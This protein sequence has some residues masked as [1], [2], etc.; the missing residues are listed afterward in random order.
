M[1]AKAKCEGKNARCTVLLKH[2]PKFFDT[3]PMAGWGWSTHHPLNLGRLVSLVAVTLCE[4]R[5][6][7]ISSCL[8]PWDSSFYLE[9]PCKK[10]GYPKASMLWPQI[11]TWRGTGSGSV[12]KSQLSPAFVA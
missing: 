7:K 12:W 6:G 11:A 10:P 5:S 4:A 2:G 9:L 8:V 1:C 3:L